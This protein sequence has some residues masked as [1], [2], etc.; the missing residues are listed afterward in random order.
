MHS[1]YA[2]SQ[3]VQQF[4]NCCANYLSTKYGA[5]ILNSSNLQITPNNCTCTEAIT[6]GPQIF[7]Y[8]VVKKRKNEAQKRTEVKFG[9]AMMQASAFLQVAKRHVL[10]E[11]ML[12]CEEIK[13]V[14]VATIE[15]CLSEG[16]S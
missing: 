2:N 6:R 16:I 11:V 7:T 5:Q 12:N 8:V 3:N 1:L 14:T 9:R 4:I 13:P 10:D 15:L